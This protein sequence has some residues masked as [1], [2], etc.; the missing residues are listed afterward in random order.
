MVKY[1]I[2]GNI[3]FYEE[4]KNFTKSSHD[5]EVI[6]EN[7]CY[8]TKEKS[9]DIENIIK[10]TCGHTFDYKPIFYE[11]LNQYIHYKTCMHS[12]GYKT[13]TYICPYCRKSIGFSSIIIPYK[14]NLIDIK[15]YGINTLEDEYKIEPI[16]FINLNK[17]AKCGVLSCNKLSMINLKNIS[18][19]AT[20]YEIQKSIEKINYQLMINKKCS[21]ILK[22]GKNK[23][24]QCQYKVACK[25]SIYCMRHKNIL[26]KKQE[27]SNEISSELMNEISNESTS[28]LLN[29]ISNLISNELLNEISNEIS[30]DKLLDCYDKNSIVNGKIVYNEILNNNEILIKI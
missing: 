29:E 7:F 22:S 14:E 21:A 13:F 24:K 25:N 30:N 17:I 15:V 20:H 5:E 12:T 6:D 4:L 1:N 11:L 8:I 16:K 9:T 26:A 18:Y 28:E 3:N 23:G 10:L 19:C 2:E 27:T